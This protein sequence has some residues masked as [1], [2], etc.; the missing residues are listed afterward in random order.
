MGGVRFWRVAFAGVIAAAG[1][2]FAEVGRLTLHAPPEATKV[3]DLN[4][5][6]MNRMQNAAIR[7]M[8]GDIMALKAKIAYLETKLL[9]TSAADS[10]EPEAKKLSGDI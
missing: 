9:E 7:K 3:R 6:E 4:G 5:V 2:L 10:S 8:A 1:P